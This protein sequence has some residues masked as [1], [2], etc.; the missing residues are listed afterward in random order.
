MEK[1]HDDYVKSNAATFNT[2]DY[3]K[4]P[5]RWLGPRSVADRDL[6]VEEAQALVAERAR[7]GHILSFAERKMLLNRIRKIK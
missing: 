1:T 2:T 5:S 3:N 6:T 4:H 7:V